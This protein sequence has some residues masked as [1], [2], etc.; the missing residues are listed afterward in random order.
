MNRS[1]LLL[2]TAMFPLWATAVH[3]APPQYTTALQPLDSLIADAAVAEV[4]V[5]SPLLLPVDARGGDIA[6]ILANGGRAETQPGS[7]FDDAGLAFRL[8]NSD[9]FTTQILNYLAGRSPFLRG[10]VGMISMAAEALSRDPRTRPV[11]IYQATWSAGGD[12][13]VVKADITAVKDLK[14]RTIALQ[15]YGPHLDYLL[16]ILADAGLGVDDVRLRWLPDLR[17]SDN[18]TLAAFRQGDVDAT[19]VTSADALALTSGD[20]PGALAG[21][22]FRG[23]RILLSTRTANRVVADLYAVRSDYLQ[24]HRQ[25]V[26]AFVHAQLKAA[27]KLHLLA[28]DKERT[29]ADYRGIMHSAAL[30]H[31]GGLTM[32]AAEALYAD[33]EFAGWQGNVNFFQSPTFPR[34]LANISSQIQPGLIKL[35]VMNSP[36]RLHSPAWDY[37]QL[38]DGLEL[39]GSLNR[40][41]FKRDKV[42]IALAR[43]QQQGNLGDSELF[44]LDLSYDPDQD[45]FPADRY[46]DAFARITDY[47][48]AYGGALVA[49]EGH[50]DPLG[51]LRQKQ[52][53]G[54]APL[55]GRIKQAARNH[56]LS[57]AVALR[58]SIVNYAMN[59]G[60]PLDYSQFAVSGEGIAKPSNGICGVD[61]CEPQSVQEWRDNMRVAIRILQVEEDAALLNTT[62][63]KP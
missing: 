63:G 51:Y 54:S 41:R 60:I 21:D 27:E 3:A 26:R 40:E 19:F 43:R 57:R 50:S 42:A 29:D 18:S 38:H 28:A 39:A 16:K 7:L 44:S 14:D 36:L 48:A 52:L 4:T 33:Y 10:T 55:L 58:D 9:S 11:V 24:S 6:T 46:S 25:E 20:T 49:L 22:S 37:A 53:G 31:D 34:S 45:D 1:M 17:G 56:S 47:A 12:A 30:L 2:L 15:A 62:P 8:V 23:A 35:G 61:P 5:E 59:H 13:L 32:T